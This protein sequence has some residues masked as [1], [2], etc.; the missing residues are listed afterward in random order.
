MNNLLTRPK[1]IMKKYHLT[2]IFNVLLTTILFAQDTKTD[3]KQKQSIYALIDKYAQSR[4]KKDSV[5]LK[6]I[7]TSDIDQLVSS[8]EW[9]NGIQGSMKGM[10]RSSSSNPGTRKLTVEKI[11]FLNSKAGIVDARYEIQR[12]DGSSRKMWSTFIVVFS[13][14]RWKISAIRNML[15]AG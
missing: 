9:R 8:G 15:P 1:Q 10:M 14:D 5:L 12:T 7:L 6:T 11:R 3:E 13:E 2:I 4:E